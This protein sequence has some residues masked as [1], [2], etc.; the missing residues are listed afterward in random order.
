MINQPDNASRIREKLKTL[1][2]FTE[3]KKFTDIPLKDGTMICTDDSDIAIG[4]IVYSIDAD[5][6]QTPCQDGTYELQDGR[7]IVVS[8]GVGAVESISD[9]SNPEDKKDASPVSDANVNQTKENMADP[10]ASTA[11]MAPEND[12]DTDNEILDRI[13][14]LESTVQQLLEMVQGMANMNKQTMSNVEP[15]IKPAPGVKEILMKSNIKDNVRNEYTELQKLNK[16]LHNGDS[17]KRVSKDEQIN[18]LYDTMKKYNFH[19]KY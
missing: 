4:S 19:K 9:A 12:A 10:S 3:V 18:S 5:G 13:S 15:E 6:N 2:K 14:A 8:G 16:E 7:T 17:V 11:P 1:F